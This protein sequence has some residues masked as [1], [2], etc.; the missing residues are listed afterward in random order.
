MNEATRILDIKD[1][2]DYHG[3]ISLLLHSLQKNPVRPPGDWCTNIPG[4]DKPPCPHINNENFVG[5][6]VAPPNAYPGHTIQFGVA[7]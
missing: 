7:A 3:T 1:G 5:R 6:S 2:E 4:S